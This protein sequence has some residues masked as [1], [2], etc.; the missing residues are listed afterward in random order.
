MFGHLERGAPEPDLDA[1][2]TRMWPLEGGLLGPVARIPPQYRLL[3][4]RLT[5]AGQVYARLFEIA[6]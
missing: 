4:Q 5:P 3:W 1:M 2:R 6:R